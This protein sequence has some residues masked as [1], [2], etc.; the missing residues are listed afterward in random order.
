MATRN[1][2]SQIYTNLFEQPPEIPS[3]PHTRFD[4]YP[5]DWTRFREGTPSRFENDPRQPAMQP[6][7]PVAATVAAPVAPHTRFDPYPIDWTR[8]REGTP[9]RFEN[10]PRQPV[11]RTA[12]VAPGIGNSFGDIGGL[13]QKQREDALPYVEPSGPNAGTVLDP[14][15]GAGT[16]N[17]MQLLAPPP[18]AAAAVP[19][20]HDV[21]NSPVSPPD[22][23]QRPPAQPAARAPVAPAQ[24]AALPV[25]PA[26]PAAPAYSAIAEA[27]AINRANSMRR[28]GIETAMTPGGIRSGPT[29]V[30][31]R[32]VAGTMRQQDA[33][34]AAKVEADRVAGVRDRETQEKRAEQERKLKNDLEVARINN[35][36]KP[37]AP[38]DWTEQVKNLT[39][40][41]KATTGSDVDSNVLWSI[42]TM[43]N[44]TED[45]KKDK[46]NAYA[47]VFKG[48]DSAARNKAIAAIESLLPP[49][50][51]QTP[52]N[53]TVNPAPATTA[54]AA[55]T[56]GS[57]LDQYRRK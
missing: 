15:P 16:A 46:S 52:T 27:E 9:S 3:A 42:S 36:V 53:T 55:P 5:I 54:T 19:I 47:S 21:A 43:P 49:T 57:I 33:Q 25:A 14:V 1:T 10:D 11:N 44:T 6:P 24:P 29:S 34:A 31:E 40:W 7:V 2:V 48:G 37:V 26:Q 13:T 30:W 39:P 17:A 56:T 18:M 12:P 32:N 35:P 45:E 8:F 51:P 50:V 28:R 38:M 41:L 4:P 23:I 22:W 20:Q